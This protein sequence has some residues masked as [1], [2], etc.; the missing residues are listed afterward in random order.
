M[1]VLMT[2]DMTEQ[3]PVEDWMDDELYAAGVAGRA[4][5]QGVH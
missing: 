1:Y 3:V 5:V 2:R 4:E